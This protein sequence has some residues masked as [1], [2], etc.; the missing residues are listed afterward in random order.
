MLSLILG[1]LA[2]F[3]PDLLGIAKAKL[4]QVHELRMLELTLKGQNQQ[5]AW[6]LEE[7]VAQG[8]ARAFEVAHKQDD[9]YGV[10]LLDAGKDAAGHLPWY[11]VPVAWLFALVD[12]LN[13]A[14]RPSITIWFLG[15]YLASKWARVQSAVD[16]LGAAP[17]AGWQT[18]SNARVAVWDDADKEILNVI[19]GF[20]FG[21]I[22][23]STGG[24]SNK[25]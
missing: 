5:A 24:Y 6:K 12:F 19:I 7:A 3:L 15:F 21:K 18:W 9:S 8:E 13:A 2:P 14:I 17:D 25:I 23:R 16:A 4:D 1:F 11:L 10:K 20:W 22:A